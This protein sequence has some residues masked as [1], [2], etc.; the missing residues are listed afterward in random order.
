[1][2]LAIIHVEQGG[3][4]FKAKIGGKDQKPVFRITDVDGNKTTNIDSKGS[5]IKQPTIDNVF[6]ALTEFLTE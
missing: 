5:V 6:T 1:M 2:E 4:H 3:R